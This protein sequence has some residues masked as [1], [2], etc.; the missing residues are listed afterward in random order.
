M[1]AKFLLILLL[2]SMVFAVSCQKRYEPKYYLAVDHEAIDFP[3]TEGHSYIQVYSTG[4]WTAEFE[5]AEPYWC[6]I[7]KTS[8]SGR[9]AI[10]LNV[11]SNLSGADRSAILNVKR[12]EVIKPI[13]INQKTVN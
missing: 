5:G 4:S 9:G 1:K 10:L 3:Y 7:D 8:G 11:D 13:K 12:G 2:A 6:R